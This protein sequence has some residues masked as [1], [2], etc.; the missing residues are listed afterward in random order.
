I[1]SPPINAVF[2]PICRFPP[3]ANFKLQKVYHSAWK[4]E[5]PG[6]K[7]VAKIRAACFGGAEKYY[8]ADA[9]TS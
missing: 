2:V 5:S 3:S 4:K 7:R 6:V 8:C 9:E 1:N